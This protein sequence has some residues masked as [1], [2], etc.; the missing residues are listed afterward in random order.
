MIPNL[1]ALTAATSD[2]IEALETQLMILVRN[3][4]LL[5]WRHERDWGMD[6]AGYLLLRTLDQIGPASINVLAETLAL[7]GSTVTRQVGAMQE[8]GL[9]E[10]E[11]NPED[12]RSCIVRPT[13]D[14]LEQMAHYRQRRRDSVTELTKDWSVHE[15]RTM[16]KMLNKLNESIMALAA[17]TSGDAK[18]RRRAR[19]RRL[20][21][22][23]GS[24]LPG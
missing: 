20:R 6:R 16:S 21:P 19:R 23:S 17:G 9:V 2:P 12:R 14:G 15:R 5:G 10:R 7:D 22:A 4:T 11:I 1:R 8:A 13:E 3:I 18:P 24:A